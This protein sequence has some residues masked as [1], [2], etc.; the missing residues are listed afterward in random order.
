MDTRRVR[1]TSN[2]PGPATAAHRSAPQRQ[3]RAPSARQ[4]EHRPHATQARAASRGLPTLLAKCFVC[5]PP[6]LRVLPE[7]AVPRRLCAAGFGYNNVSQGTSP[8]DLR[9][10]SA[11]R[12]LERSSQS[13]GTRHSPRREPRRD[14]CG[15]L[16]TPRGRRQIRERGGAASRAEVE[17]RFMAR[18]GFHPAPRAPADGRKTLSSPGGPGGVTPGIISTR[19]L[20]ALVFTSLDGAGHPGHPGHPGVPS[21]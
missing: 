3:S 8:I 21:Q 2:K 20:V 17:M 12:M 16:W 5:M 19:P 1:A 14:C 18:Q 13:E 10:C 4:A 6:A 11:V 9:Y 15:Q 7:L